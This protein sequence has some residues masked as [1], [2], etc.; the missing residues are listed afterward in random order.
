MNKQD[1][2][3]LEN[4]HI[5][6]KIKNALETYAIYTEDNFDDE[7]FSLGFTT[8]VSTDSSILDDCL[9]LSSQED[10]NSED[11]RFIQEFKY[12]NKFITVVYET[13]DQALTYTIAEK[14]ETSVLL[15]ELSV[16]KDLVCDNDELIEKIENQFFKEFL[17]DN[18]NS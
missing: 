10:L 9:K 1:I 18:L 14:Y 7:D 12:K 4:D 16:E 5:F 2:N 17:L 3:N 13:P 11:K 15:D 8:I 6:K